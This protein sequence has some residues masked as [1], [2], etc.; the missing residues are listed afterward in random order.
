MSTVPAPV[1]T[2]IRILR[3]KY[4]SGLKLREVQ[5]VLS[6]GREDAVAVMRRLITMGQAETYV[7][8]R[9]RW[10]SVPP[11]DGKPRQEWIDQ[12]ESL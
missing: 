4:P 11:P 2:L 1:R 7:T 9:R 10:K 5:N 8:E 6:C 3:T 12:A